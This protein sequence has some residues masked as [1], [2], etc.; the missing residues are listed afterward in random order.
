M[1]K[2]LVK[3]KILY[4]VVNHILYI[5]YYNNQS[6]TLCKEERNVYCIYLLFISQ[7]LL[8]DFLTVSR[9]DLLKLAKLCGT[10]FNWAIGGGETSCR[11]FLQSW[12]PFAITLLIAL[13]ISQIFV[14]SRIILADGPLAKY[15]TGLPSCVQTPVTI[16][17]VSCALNRKNY[18]S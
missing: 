17:R 7:N 15:G 6:Y 10:I 14:A 8:T 11:R 13:G 3:I 4:I 16:T 2:K 9:K 1:K 12:Q 5:L 18:N